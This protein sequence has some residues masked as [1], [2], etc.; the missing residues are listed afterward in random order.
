[1]KVIFVGCNPSPNNTTSEPFVGTKSNKTLQAWVAEL[2]LLP[3][4]CGYVNVTDQVTKKASQ[5]KKSDVDLRDFNLSLLLKA[6][7]MELGQPDA[8]NA[9]M[10]KMQAAGRLEDAFT[11]MPEEEMN[12][13]LEKVKNL[14]MPRVIAL[15]KMAVWA[16]SEIDL[17]HFELPHPS[18][19]NRTLNNKEALQNVLA[20]CKSWLYST[21][22]ESTKG[23]E[24]GQADSPKTP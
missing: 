21:P 13:Y 1:V 23:D 10:A 2:G 19:L 20:D 5:V 17:P 11:P 12:S 8:T 7:E 18:G 16:L 24:N 14:P 9:M 22:E 3:E 15:G 4:Q 6:L